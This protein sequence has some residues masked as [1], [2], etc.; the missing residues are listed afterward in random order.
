MQFYQSKR[1]QSAAPI[2]D[3]FLFIGKLSLYQ[4]LHGILFSQNHCC[5]LDLFFYFY[6]H[7]LAIQQKC[8]PTR[9]FSVSHSYAY[10][11]AY[12]HTFPWSGRSSNILMSS[13]ERCCEGCF[14]LSLTVMY[15]KETIFTKAFEQANLRVE[16]LQL[17]RSSISIYVTYK[18]VLL[19][20]LYDAD[21]L[22]FL[23]AFIDPDSSSMKN[24]QL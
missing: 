7:E 4:F 9:Q 18:N 22:L 20:R 10:Q 24:P 23:A 1:S 14:I 2:L 8:S 6:K 19:Y 13:N 21:T 11:V 5:L 3:I 12:E 17:L 15:Q 16:L